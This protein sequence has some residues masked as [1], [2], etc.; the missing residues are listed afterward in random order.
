MKS[1]KLFFEKLMLIILKKNYEK[2]IK[3]TKQRLI[4]VLLLGFTVIS[5][6]VVRKMTSLLIMEKKTI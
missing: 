3:K 2:T 6:L 1:C 4:G 5:S